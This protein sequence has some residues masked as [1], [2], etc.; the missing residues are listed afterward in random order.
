MICHQ[1][2]PGVSIPLRVMAL[3]SLLKALLLKLNTAYLHM[4]YIQNQ[5]KQSLLIANITRISQLGVL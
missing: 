1:A 2:E 5:F 3:D 4:L